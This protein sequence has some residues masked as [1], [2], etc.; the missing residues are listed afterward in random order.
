MARPRLPG[1]P[2]QPL[3]EEL[4]RERVVAAG[5]SLSEGPRGVGQHG[6]HD[7]RVG[8]HQ[9][10]A[11]PEPEHERATVPLGPLAVV[12]RDAGHDG[13]VEGRERRGLGGGEQVA[14]ACGVAG[15]RAARRAPDALP[16]EP[17]LQAA[18]DPQEGVEQAERE[19]D[20]GGEEG[21][22]EDAQQRGHRSALAAADRLSRIGT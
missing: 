7:L 12:R 3:A 1:E 5:A 10:R 8:D 19:R 11:G 9:P 13:V 2:H 17:A 18:R 4:P 22:E 16:A 20:G 6:L 15:E 21:H 14:V